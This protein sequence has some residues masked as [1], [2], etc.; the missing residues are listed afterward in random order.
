MIGLWKTRRG[1]GSRRRTLARVVALVLPVGLFGLG[2]GS[3]TPPGQT[4]SA[5]SQGAQD[6]TWMTNRPFLPPPDMDKINYD[7]RTRTLSLYDLPGNDRWVVRMAGESAGLH[8]PPRHRIPDVD[9][10][11]VLVYYV[12]PGCQSSVPVTVKMIQDSGGSHVSMAQ[13]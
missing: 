3:P 5:H 12:R 13:R 4:P 2:C 1:S 7:A 11:D 10:N 6:S 8:V 9:P